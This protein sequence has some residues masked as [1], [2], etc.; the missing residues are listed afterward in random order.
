[1]V[2]FSETDWIT[3]F[4][5]SAILLA[6]LL[7]NPRV[8]RTDLIR[9]STLID[10]LLQLHPGFRAAYNRNV[11]VPWAVRVG[12]LGGVLLVTVTGL[13]AV[14][15][16]P[17]SALPLALYAF[18]IV[19]DLITGR[20]DRRARAG[21]EEALKDPTKAPT[22]VLERHK[23]APD[24]LFRTLILLIFTYGLL[25]ALIAVKASEVFQPEFYAYLGLYLVFG[26]L[27]VI[28]R[29]QSFVRVQDILFRGDSSAAGAQ[30]LVRVYVS[31]SGQDTP[32]PLTGSLRGV[33]LTLQVKGDDGFVHDINWSAVSR[34]AVRA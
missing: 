25:A 19:P 10:S 21:L 28:Q 4:G 16:V 6:A 27:Y 12:F 31:D 29:I 5:A 30:V 8:L 3:L 33:G 26:P 34:I 23:I 14:D 17:P 15:L 24:I 1:M 7:T 11:A 13:L 32:E 20:I 22:A 9:R 18:F 2:S